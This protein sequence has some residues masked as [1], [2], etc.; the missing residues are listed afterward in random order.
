MASPGNAEQWT[1]EAT[2]PNPN[3]HGSPGLF[4]YR[5]TAPPEV[6]AFYDNVTVTAAEDGKPSE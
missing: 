2:D 3:D 5:I 1:L 6:A 4:T